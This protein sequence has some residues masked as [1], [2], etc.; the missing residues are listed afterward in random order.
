MQHDGT[1]ASTAKPA[2][3]QQMHEQ[4]DNALGLLHSYA[5]S[6]VPNS[7]SAARLTHSTLFPQQEAGT[8]SKAPQPE[9]TI[10]VSIGRIEVRAFTPPPA[11]P[12]RANPSSR[13]MSLDEYLNKSSQRGRG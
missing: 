5:S 13:P 3:L 11:S 8:P 1:L 12:K 6:L 2:I 9:S 7:G 4:N 10:N